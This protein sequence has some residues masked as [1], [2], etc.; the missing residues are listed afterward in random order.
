MA[1]SNATIASDGKVLARCSERNDVKRHGDERCGG[2]E[3][4]STEG[5]YDKEVGH[6]RDYGKMTLMKRAA[7]SC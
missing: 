5:E 7:A 4:S 2:A 6:L 1:R 3:R